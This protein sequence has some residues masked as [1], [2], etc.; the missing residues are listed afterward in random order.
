M[1]ASLLKMRAQ[2]LGAKLEVKRTEMPFMQTHA[3]ASS[4][5]RRQMLL[6]QADSIY[7]KDT[8][9]GVSKAQ[10]EDVPALGRD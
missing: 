7:G 1:V 10:T 9:I 6:A 3:D 8:G 2:C 5:C 4:K